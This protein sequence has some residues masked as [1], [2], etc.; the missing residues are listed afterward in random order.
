MEAEADISGKLNILQVVTLLKSH[1]VH[2]VLIEGGAAI[3]TSFIQ[4]HMWDR[5]SIFIAPMFVG[6]GLHALADLGIKK[7][8]DAIHCDDIRYEIIG[9]NIHCMINNKK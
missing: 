9:N 6:N 3:L 5:I 2:S 7:I 4:Q 8:S 1:N